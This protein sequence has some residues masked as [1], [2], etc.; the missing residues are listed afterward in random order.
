[1]NN[2]PA[3]DDL[4]SINSLVSPYKKSPHLPF[5]R[6]GE[7]GTGQKSHGRA[8]DVAP[9]PPGLLDSLI[10]SGSAGLPR[11]EG[12][13]GSRERV[14]ARREP[15]PV[16]GAALLRQVEQIAVSYL[17]SWIALPTPTCSSWA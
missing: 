16:A 15:G 2:H 1:M 7:E 13:R 4:D 12:P 3:V 11:R 10:L 17:F 8:S 6:G 14:W 5:P 9:N